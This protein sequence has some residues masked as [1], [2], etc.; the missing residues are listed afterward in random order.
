MTPHAYLTDYNGNRK[1]METIGI[2]NIQEAV[3]P[4]P[5][6]GEETLPDYSLAFQNSGTVAFPFS[7]DLRHTIL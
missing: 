1:A 7:V 6:S 3:I 2:N 4:I 5:R